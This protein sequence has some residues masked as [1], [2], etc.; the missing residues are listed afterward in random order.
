MN[1][2][3]GLIT[4]NISSDT[5]ATGSAINVEINGSNF[6]ESDMFW[7]D[8]NFD[9]T[10]FSFD[11]VSM[12]SDLSLVD[13]SLGAFDG[14]EVTSE[15][16]GLGFLFS[17]VFSPVTGDFT[18]ATFDLVA[19][20]EGTSSFDISGLD[21]FAIDFNVTPSYDVNFAN[22]NSVNSEAVS[23]AEPSTIFLA[24]MLLVP[25]LLSANRRVQ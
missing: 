12:S 9:N 23:V 17:D 10:I 20:T 24:L 18:I 1:A 8:F 15:S 3:A 13:S 22:G 2:N 25:F 16:F 7:F 14:L 11:S 4:V 19:E 21:G 6:V 5:V